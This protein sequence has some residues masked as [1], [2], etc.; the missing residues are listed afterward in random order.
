MNA[1]TLEDQVKQLI[2]D[3]HEL[4]MQAA[5]DVEQIENLQRE[6]QQIRTPFS[7]EAQQ[8]ELRDVKCAVYEVI[9]VC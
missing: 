8:E 5:S 6:L 1:E 9:N 2:K 4:R 3:N 7:L